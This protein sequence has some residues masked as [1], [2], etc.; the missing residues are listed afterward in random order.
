MYVAENFIFAF[1]FGML[2]NNLSTMNSYSIK[3]IMQWQFYEHNLQW[4]HSVVK[5]KSTVFHI[6][7]SGNFML[8]TI[9]WVTFMIMSTT[10]CIWNNDLCGSILEK[11]NITNSHYTTRNMRECKACQYRWGGTCF[12][13]PWNESLVLLSINVRMVVKNL[14]K[15][16]VYYDKNDATVLPQC[17]SPTFI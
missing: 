9:N 17:Y 7:I 14:R 15:R 12:I 13:Y 4:K 10:Y 6:I 3:F 1:I 2:N 8:Q 11:N 5:H 16:L